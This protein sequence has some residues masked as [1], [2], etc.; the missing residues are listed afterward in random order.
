MQ[1]IKV[2]VY[3]TPQN[4]ISVVKFMEEQRLPNESRAINKMISKYLE[5]VQFYQSNIEKMQSKLIEFHQL[6]REKDTEINMLNEQLKE[7]QEKDKDA[8]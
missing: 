1:K 6:V 3:I 2:Q 5:Q 7:K 4:Y 8:D